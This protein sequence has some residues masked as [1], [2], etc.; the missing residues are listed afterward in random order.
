[1]HDA[2]AD[3]LGVLE[4]GDH[5]EDTLLL[6]ELQVGLETDQVE[7]G[8]LSVVLAQ[9]ND[10]VGLLAGVG[11]GQ[12]NGLQGAVAQGVK[13]AAGHDFHGHA[14]FEDIVVLETMD[15]GSLGGHQFLVEGIILL[16]IHGAVDVVGVAAVIAGLPPGLGHVDGLHGDQGCCGVKEMQVIGLTEILANGVGQGIGSQRTGSHDDRTLG[17]LG[18]FLLDD[19]DVGMI[20][21]LLGDHLGKAHT[22]NGQTA[23]GFHAGS[24]GALHDDAA[25]A[26]QLFLQ[27]TDRIFQTVAPEGIG[28]DKLCEIF[29]MMGG[30]LLGRTHLVEFYLDA[31]LGQLP[32]G[33][34]AC[35]ACADDFY[36]HA[37]ASFFL[38]EV[39]LLV[40]FF[41]VV[42]FLAAVFLVEAFFAAGF[43]A[44]F[45]SSTTISPS[46]SPGTDSVVFFL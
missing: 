8:L 11:I 14:A 27:Q 23:A 33:F 18:D 37:S 31:P 7:D 29:G 22:V 13:T 21:D 44:V 17:D 15:L 26:A 4:A 35:Q 3:E 38:E 16:F 6:A 12:T 40:V 2:V 41:V 43:F 36:F 1:M 45:F 10:S 28:A 19:G 42:V 9:L 34:R 25:H 32:G 39:F 20:S 24:L 46:G 30:T 5:G